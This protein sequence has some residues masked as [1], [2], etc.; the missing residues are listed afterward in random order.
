MAA[1]KKL[2]QDEKKAAGRIDVRAFAPIAVSSGASRLGVA[3]LVA[4]CLAPASQ[5]M[6]NVMLG[7]WTGATRP[8]RIRLHDCMITK[9]GR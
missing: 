1:G 6:A 7:R 4:L 5:I 9:L 8:Y 3:V 2:V